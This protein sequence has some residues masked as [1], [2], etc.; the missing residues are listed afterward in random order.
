M[1]DIIYI[2]GI[3]RVGSVKSRYKTSDLKKIG[4]LTCILI[5]IKNV[6]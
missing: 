1:A 5:G 4:I 3:S 6:Y 2:I